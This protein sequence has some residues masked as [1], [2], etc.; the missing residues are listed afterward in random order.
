MLNNTSYLDDVFEKAAEQG[1]SSVQ[2]TKRSV[3]K[4]SKDATRDLGNSFFGTGNTEK[5]QSM[6][7]TPLDANHIKQFEKNYA[8]QDAKKIE[9][10]KAVLFK[11]VNEE[12]AKA[13]GQRRREEEERKQQEEQ[14]ELADKQEREQEKGSFV[15][16]P[17]GKAKRGSLQ[18]Q[19]KQ[20][21]QAETRGGKSQF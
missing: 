14:E 7:H 20:N 10:L 9:E 15:T 21:T 16:M 6:N 11:R 5:L 18:K 3:I 13:I 17:T 4:S 8:A 12:S 1:R 19:V 2:K